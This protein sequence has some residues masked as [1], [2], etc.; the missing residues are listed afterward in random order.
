MKKYLVITCVILGMALL[1]G[2]AYT[3][4]FT[5]TH[6]NKTDT[7]IAQDCGHEEQIQSLMRQIETQQNRISYFNELVDLYQRVLDEFSKA[8]DTQYQWVEELLEQ[9]SNYTELLN[10]ANAE[11]RELERQVAQ[12]QAEL[13]FL[14]NKDD[15]FDDYEI[16]P[17]SDTDYN[18]VSLNGNNAELITTTRGNS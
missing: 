16:Q 18:F 2:F 17:F 5:A 14:L 15:E 4:Y 6:S 12:L 9:V 10:Q 3:I 7:D 13:D 11:I 8:F 1:G